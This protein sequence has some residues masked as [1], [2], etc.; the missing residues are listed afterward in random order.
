MAF[1]LKSMALL[2]VL[3]GL[4]VLY[5][6]AS[7]QA[8]SRAAELQLLKVLGARH[9]DVAQML[10]LEFGAIGFLGAALGAAL[11]VALSYT[12]SARIFDWAWNFSWLLPLSSI[13]AVTALTLGTTQV[14][15]LRTLRKKP[16]LLLAQN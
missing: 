2:S 12:I 7:H 14:A 9:A 5:S 4:I 8:R 13:L 11:S 6:I 3:T 1:A 16:A 10:W 15:A